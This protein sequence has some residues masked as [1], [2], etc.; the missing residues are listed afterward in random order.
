MEVGAYLMTDFWE[1]CGAANVEDGQRG[2]QGME[3]LIFE[4][5][6]P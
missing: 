5:T 2:V 4:R 3:E 1:P 6:H